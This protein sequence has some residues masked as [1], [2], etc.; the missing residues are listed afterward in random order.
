MFFRILIA[1]PYIQN[2]KDG[3]KFIENGAKMVLKSFE[4]F[5]PPFGNGFLDITKWTDKVSRPAWIV[6]EFSF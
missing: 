6:S 5:Q 2:I 1:D 4:E 3:E